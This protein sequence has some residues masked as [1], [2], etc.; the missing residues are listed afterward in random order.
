MMWAYVPLLL[1]GMSV[2]TLAA[3]N[4]RRR[5]GFVVGIA[6]QG[7]WLVFD[8]H[9]GAVGL[10]PLAFVYGP[11]YAHGWWLWRKTE[12]HRADEG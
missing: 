8:W 10:M 1:T 3:I 12:Y 11:L 4:F 9:V 2:V 5:F 7:V 6:A